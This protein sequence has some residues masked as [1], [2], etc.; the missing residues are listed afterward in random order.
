ASPS[1]AG[2]PALLRPHLD[3]TIREVTLE[4][5]AFSAG[6]RFEAFAVP[7]TLP[8]G[9]PATVIVAS[10]LADFEHSVHV[11]G[12]FLLSALPILLALVAATSWVV[13]GRS[14]QPVEAMRAEVSEITT[15]R[16]NRRVP[17]PAADDEVGR[18]AVTLNQMLDRLEAST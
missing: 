13:I 11:L 18:L 6:Q 3:R 15:R 1:L 8:G 12:K 7:V 9:T 10:S 2:Q 5:P 14:L 16:L 17:V 4:H